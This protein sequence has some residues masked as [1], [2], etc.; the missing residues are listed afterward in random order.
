[1]AGTDMRQPQP[2][3][4]D[5]DRINWQRARFDYHEDSDTLYWDFL[6]ETRS[7]VSRPYTEN[8]I[9]SVDPRTEDVV[10]FQFDAF[11]PRRIDHMPELEPVADILRR[12]VIGDEEPLAGLDPF[13]AAWRQ[14]RALSGLLDLIRPL[15]PSITPPAALSGQ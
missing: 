7:A 3:W 4:P 5:I 14:R 9:L 12:T 6:S 2:R 15:A 8:I 11:T 10:G 1:M 13:D